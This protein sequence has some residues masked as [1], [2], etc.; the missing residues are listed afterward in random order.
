MNTTAVV[1]GV[2]GVAV[3]GVG[4]W[5]VGQRVRAE[6]RVGTLAPGVPGA[7]APNIPTHTVAPRNEQQQAT[8]RQLMT[9]YR[10]SLSRL[11]S[12]RMTIQHEIQQAETQGAAACSRYALDKRTEH[13]CHET[14]FVRHDCWW[15]GV[16]TIVNQHVQDQCNQVVRGLGDIPPR[17]PGAY[18]A[19]PRGGFGDLPA[20]VDQART[21]ALAAREA[22][23]RAQARLRDVDL[24]I[25]DVEKKIADLNAQGVF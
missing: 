19:A 2:G 17:H 23:Q 25:A 12:E 15:E 24:Q 5:I 3:V 9:S 1:L 11:Q 4:L 16:G 13:R 10:Q 22:R 6:E 8:L 14:L 18:P 21:Q 20:R 7:Y